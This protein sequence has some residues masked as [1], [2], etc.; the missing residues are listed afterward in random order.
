[1]RKTVLF[2]VLIISVSAVAGNVCSEDKALLERIEWSDIWVVNA[3]I[4]DLPRVLLVGDSIVRGY[5]ATVEKEL[6]GAADCARYATSKFLGNPGYLAE[7]ELLLKEYRFDVVHINN[8]LHGWAYTEQQYGDSIPKLLAMIQKQAPGAALIWATTTPVRNRDDLSR[9]SDRTER[10]RER[11][12]IALEI[13]KKRGV[14]VDDLCG[15][16]ENR[17]DFYA[18]D[19]THFNEKGR[20]AQGKQVAETIRKFLP[21]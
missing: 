14:P 20:A 13:L 1:V 21:K 18:G 8:G 16:V 9:L 3:N 6:N 7:L 2:V 15:L 17:P 4:D 11:N 12:R 5:F 10:V 19:G